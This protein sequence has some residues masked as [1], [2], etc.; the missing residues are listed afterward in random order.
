MAPDNK[1]MKDS[2]PIKQKAMLGFMLI[3]VI[4]IL[5]QLKGLFW[6]ESSHPAPKPAAVQTASTKANETTSQQQMSAASPNAPSANPVVVKQ[7]PS[8]TQLPIMA[9]SI[10][11]QQDSDQDNS[12]KKY[13]GKIDELESLK[14][15]RQIAET[16][17]AIAAARLAT[18][19]AEKGITD[20]LTS[21]KPQPV[22]VPQAVY[23]NQLGNS[24]II[25][26][27]TPSSAAAGPPDRNNEPAA[28]PE[29]EYSV[30][31]VAMQLHKWSA[32]LGYQGKL[33]NV[34]VGD[35]LPPDNSKVAKITSTYV[36]LKKEG[37]SRRIS[38]LSS[39]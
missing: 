28:E 32:I 12:E 38:V 2:M 11:T 24:T 27:S 35:T 14:I 19:T 17:Q 9:P 25:T 34:S 1:Q 13:L 29:I 31:S 33:Y 21:S 5:W 26:S 18:V 10:S 15:Q 37:K 4:A 23:A 8:I 16:N 22:A 36:V 7:Q 3:V 20:L 6:G 39:I 30:I